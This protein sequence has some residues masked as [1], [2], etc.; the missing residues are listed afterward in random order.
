LDFRAEMEEGCVRKHVKQLSEDA[1]RRTESV[2][3]G[4]IV[5]ALFAALLVCAALAASASATVVYQNIPTKLPGDFPS[6]SFAFDATGTSQFGGEV[7]LTAAGD[8]NP[9]VTF[10]LSSWACE[11]GSWY[12]QNCVSAKGAKFSWPIT[13]TLYRVGPDNTPGEVIAAASEVM[14]I[15]YRP[16]TTPVCNGTEK[17]GPEEKGGWYDTKES[18]CDEGVA[19]KVTENLKA[20]DLPQKMIVAISYDTT[21][22]GS[23]PVGEKPCDKEPQGCPYDSL[24]V[25][26]YDGVT[27]GS[28]PLP[29]DAFVNSAYSFAY[30]GSGVTPGT[31]GVSY[32]WTG[33][34]PAIE[35]TA[36]A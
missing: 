8:K 4:R 3:V 23:A 15:P 11:K 5:G 21:S 2:G 19:A 25:G 7:E 36:S 24:N 20:T 35:V 22:Y 28:Y 9:K 26:V 18:V 10:G 34:Q 31:F 6:G 30:D 1:M 32:E 16:S 27:I 17:N 12:D 13:V 29:E 33:Y 14:K